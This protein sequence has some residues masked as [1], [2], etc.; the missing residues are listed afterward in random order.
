MGNNESEPRY[1]VTQHNYNDKYRITYHN[2]PNSQELLRIFRLFS[3]DPFPFIQ[4]IEVLSEQTTCCDRSILKVTT[5]QHP[6]NLET[7]LNLKRKTK[8]FLV[9]K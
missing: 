1:E 6:F 9:E 2:H 4:S 8:G 5:P 3:K 7:L